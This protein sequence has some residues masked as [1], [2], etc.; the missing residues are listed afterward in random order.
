MILPFLSLYIQTL[1]QFSDA[2]VQRWAGFVFGI[3]F[4]TG[5]FLSPVWGR[6]SDKYGFKPILLL[7]GFGIATSIFLMGFIQSVEGLFVLRLFQGVVTGF[8][9]TALAFIA[10][11]TPK[12]VA[13]KTL[14]TLQMGTVSG[15][16]FG[17]L[18]GGLLADA[19]GF[20][21]TFIITASTIALAATLVAIGVKEN[22]A[23]IAKKHK[24]QVSRRKVLQF[25]YHEKTLLVIMS[26]TLI[27]QIAIFSIQPLL[28]LYVGELT[29]T[30]NV[31]FLA[32]LAFS[33]TGFGNLLFTR[34][35]GSLA[36]TYG[37]EKILLILLLLGAILFIPQAF[38][39]SLWQLVIFR[40]LFGLVVGGIMPS[41]TAF[42]RHN[43]PL[44]MQ[45]EVL[46][47]NNSFRLLGNVI[48]PAFGGIV[49]GLIGISSVFLLTSVIFLGGFFLLR[50][51][52]KSQKKAK[53]AT[54]NDGIN[55]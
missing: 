16:L 4:L 23:A 6:I 9:P 43:A 39:T 27:V 31:A 49:S 7:T 55:L 54:E 18:I 19:F 25:I 52:I 5:F 29:S 21:Y 22:R 42:I 8:T 34:K 32:G 2:Y 35:W 50:W 40:F 51:S 20:Q 24:Q 14:G 12:E 10:T 36:D 48:G 33:A 45:G 41:I 38:V 15:G 30:K 1:G 13:G 17:P 11:Q 46:G 26:L 53:T 37:Y 3:T 44:S 47:Y 28:A